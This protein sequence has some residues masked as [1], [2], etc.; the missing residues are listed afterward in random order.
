MS[1]F[2]EK[3]SDRKKNK[4]SIIRLI[5][6]NF[7]TK[8]IKEVRVFYTKLGEI[9]IIKINSMYIS[10][11]IK[12]IKHQE[13]KLEYNIIH[14]TDISFT[15]KY[16]E[17][18]K[19][20]GQILKIVKKDISGNVLRKYTIKGLCRK[21]SNGKLLVMLSLE[22]TF[23]TGTAGAERRRIK[24]STQRILLDEEI[25]NNFSKI[26]NSDDKKTDVDSF[27]IYK[28]KRFLDYRSKMIY[29]YSFINDFLCRYDSGC[30]EIWK[31]YRD[32]NKSSA[33]E[34]YNTNI[35][36]ITIYLENYTSMFIEN[37]NNFIE[38]RIKKEKKESEKIALEKQKIE[39]TMNTDDTKKIMTLLNSVRHKLMHY[40]YSFFEKLFT[41][42][43]IIIE[44]KKGD[45]VCSETLEKLLDL[46]FFKELEKI[47]IIKGEKSTTYL[48]D[49]TK[50]FIL[51][52]PNKKAKTVYNIYQK[53]CERKNGFNSFINSFFVT[54][55][56]ENEKNKAVII[57]DFKKRLENLKNGTKKDK[58][59]L[60]R[61]MG[62][63][64]KQLNHMPYIWDIHLSRNYKELYN[65]SKNKAAEL[66]KL[67]E[68][69]PSVERTEKITELNKALKVIKEK[70]KKLTKLNAI[71]RLEY[72]MRIAFGFLYTEYGLD[73]EKFK[74]DFDTNKT[75][76]IKN[77]RNN[78]KD[79]LEARSKVVNEKKGK[80]EYDFELGNFDCMEEIN[81]DDFLNADKSNN[82][83]KMY[84]LIFLLLPVEVRGDFL[85]FVKKHYYDMKNTE[86]VS[87]E[88]NDKTDFFHKLRLF[89]KNTKKLEIIKYSLAE[90]SGIGDDIEERLN[91]I[92]PKGTG[93][94]KILYK[95]FLRPF[96]RFYENFMKLANDA[97]IHALL[98]VSDK[99]GI[100]VQ[101]CMEDDELKANGYYNFKKLMIVAKGEKEGK[102]YNVA[103]LRN[104]I[105][106]TKYKQLYIDPLEGKENNDINTLVDDLIK[107]I[108]YFGIDKQ[109]LGYN[110]IND[111]YQRQEELLF[112]IKKNSFKNIS[113]PEKEDEEE[114]YIKKFNLYSD[115][116]DKPDLVKIDN[117]IQNLKNICDE[118]INKITDNKYWDFLKNEEVLI[119]NKEKKRIKVLYKEPKYIDNIY[120]AL[121]KRINI[122]TGI[123]KKYATCKINEKISSILMTGEVRYVNLIVYDKTEKDKMNIRLD[124]RKSEKDWNIN[125]SENNIKDEVEKF[126][127]YFTYKCNKMYFTL[128][129]ITG[130]KIDVKKIQSSYIHKV[131]INIENDKIYLLSTPNKVKN[132]G[133]RQ[134][135]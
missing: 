121:K 85:G 53:I 127:N 45:I 108:R 21:T 52:R 133:V 74:N 23:C 44:N 77:F 134:T 54:D 106:H 12:T 75:D 14:F 112:I 92:L 38:N 37:H 65:E 83:V 50:L 84:L 109:I 7:D 34:I 22:D 130:N 90:V 30:K 8:S 6:S 48:E 63:I 93:E 120:G 111:Y 59:I 107:G 43:N 88:L 10:D 123:Y 94:N 97:E 98:K 81:K 41:G 119:T 5:I 49:D 35:E 67:V 39:N 110:Y 51:G 102:K 128:Y 116:N 72:K 99:K 80:K 113:T 17:V 70:M 46:S 118:N 11:E 29:Y 4:N 82:L 1:Q 62:E 132:P 16:L 104:R 2:N 135:F 79:Y 124:L 32:N 55:G 61:D 126:K 131:K 27:M 31:V 36:N 100:P 57:E 18:E 15:T 58:V 117:A 19:S 26:I 95:N 42:E 28:A 25:T 96:T 24:T 129:D 33:E 105:A 76:E 47:K 86:F 60:L 101:K 56:I 91:D 122:L 20:D 40:D 103:E 13:N 66:S 69:E 71:F 115:D 78:F 114:N 125:Y 68:E 89:E 87:E 73:L 64:D 3:N 9:D